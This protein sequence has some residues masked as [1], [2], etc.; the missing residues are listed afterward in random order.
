MKKARLKTLMYWDLLS[1]MRQRVGRVLLVTL[2]LVCTLATVIGVRHARLLDQ[3]QTDAQAAAERAR[4]AL[5][6]RMATPGGTPVLPISA[7]LALVTP[8]APLAALASGRSLLDPQAATGSAF[9][10]QQNL[11]RDYQLDSPVALASGMFDL[12]FVIVALL[13]LW[14]NALAHGV[15]VEDRVRGMDRVLAVQN[16]AATRW[17]WARSLV[18][19]GLLL[20]PVLLS[21]G[22][23][24]ITTGIL[25]RWHAWFTAAVLTT[26][27]VAFWWSLSSWISTWSGPAGR[28]LLALLGCWTVLVLL[29]PAAVGSITRHVHPPPSRLSLIAAARS[30][31]IDG[32]RR[33]SELVGAYAHD[34]PELDA[35]ASAD[36]PGWARTG[37]LIA[38][39][40]DHQTAPLLLQFDR[41]LEAQFKAVARWQYLSPALLLQH[42]LVQLAGTDEST[43]LAF[44]NQAHRAF[45]A[46]REHV[47]ALT[48]A[49]KALDPPLLAM[50]PEFAFEPVQRST[51]RIGALPALLFGG[52]AVG[53]A[54]ATRR[55]LRRHEAPG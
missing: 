28:S 31:E 34:H 4:S 17:W 37:F 22:V 10:Q 43:T 5:L 11:F 7:R 50:L 48:L 46:F 21:M 6:T 23:L 53:L 49:G 18:R 42:S 52:F 14:V 9:S 3:R 32:T 55:A 2:L 54:L 39:E 20:L 41:A 19:C 38:Q 35:G 27:Y 1:L 51:I 45:V 30:A 24:A 33:A 25:A 40:V 13:P 29:V 12:A 44:R 36:L 47:G 8:P 16:L 26:G 15:I